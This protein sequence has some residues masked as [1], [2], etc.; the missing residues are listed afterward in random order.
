MRGNR[1]GLLPRG[2]RGWYP[3]S[4]CAYCGAR[5]ELREAILVTFA[6]ALVCVDSAACERRCYWQRVR[7]FERVD[8]GRAA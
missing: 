3:F 4:S 2:E 6:V 8:Q 1:L 7:A 5:G